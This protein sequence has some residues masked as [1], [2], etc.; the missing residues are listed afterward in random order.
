MLRTPELSTSPLILCIDDNEE[1]LHLRKLVLETAGYS[2]LIAPDGARGLEL[3]A[4]NPVAGVVLDYAMPGMNGGEV[5]AEMRKLKPE[6]PIILL[7]GCVSEMPPDALGRVD[8]FI[9]KG[10]P[11]NSLTDALKQR[12][13]AVA[14]ER[15]Q[16]KRQ[17]LIARAEQIIEAS[18][19][20]A[21]RGQQVARRGR[22]HLQAIRD[23]HTKHQK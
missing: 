17:E 20:V 13:S 9:Q 23:R 6:V 15:K 4:N 21:E 22:Q 10:S 14:T 3:F 16:P 1:G 8:Q 19:G 7:S 18:R 12:V 11:V 2:V 5:A